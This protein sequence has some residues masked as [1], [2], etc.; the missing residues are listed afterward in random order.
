MALSAC[1]FDLD[2]VLV[3]TAKY[4]F[5]AWK[6]LANSLGFDFSQAQNEELK[7]IS[8][9]ESLRKIL[10]WGG[11]DLPQSRQEELA[12]LKNG[13]YVEMISNMDETELLPGSL[14]LL[15]SL[16]A[17]RIGIALGSASKNA[18]L[19]LARTGISSYFDVIVD[20]NM[21][22]KSKPDPEVFVRG[23]ELLQ[24]PASGCIVFE[25]A[26]AGIEAAKRAHMKTI[27]IGQSTDLPAADIVVPDLSKIDLDTLERLCC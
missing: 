4:H 25:D 11:L 22:S 2:G 15:E 18:K 20:G 13:W 10:A 9:V 1:L 8:R 7:G 12:Q 17:H 6:Q 27:G 26:S 23:A 16:R 24:V 19:I 14:S 3:D 5:L 21:V